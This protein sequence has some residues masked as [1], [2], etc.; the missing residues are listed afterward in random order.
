MARLV[1]HDRDEPYR[2]EPQDKPVFVCACG[3]S[4]NLP[5]CDGSHSSCRKNEEP[6]KLYRYDDDRKAIV[7]EVDE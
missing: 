6:G 5:I 7:G 4:K 1:R 3:L 2:I